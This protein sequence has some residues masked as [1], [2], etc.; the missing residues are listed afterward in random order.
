MFMYIIWKALRPQ[1][2]LDWGFG[3]EPCASESLW[4]M[5]VQRHNLKYD[6]MS[7]YKSQHNAQRFWFSTKKFISVKSQY[8]KLL[9]SQFEQNG[10]II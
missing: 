7:E 10:K 9:G 2:V 6:V 3:K 1:S 5:Q 4:C 8:E